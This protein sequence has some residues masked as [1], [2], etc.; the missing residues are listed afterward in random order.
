MGGF[1]IV[2]M[3]LGNFC[4]GLCVVVVFV[5]FV[6]VFWGV[7]LVGVVVFVLVWCFG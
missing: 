1:K 2:V 3:G 6:V 4:L 7:F 5:F